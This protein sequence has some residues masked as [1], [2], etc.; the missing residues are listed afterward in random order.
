MKIGLVSSTIPL[1]Q[2]GGR[3]IVDWLAEK[4]VA[5]GHSVE[6]VW[7]PYTDEVRFMFAEMAAFRLAKGSR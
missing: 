7:I 4:L 5:A 3:F 6:I 1:V 2:G